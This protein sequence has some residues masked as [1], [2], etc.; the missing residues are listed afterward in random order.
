MVAAF[1]DG[2]GGYQGQLGLPLQVGDGG[3]AHV[4]HG[5]LDL[6]EAGLHVVMEGAGGFPP[7]FA[8]GQL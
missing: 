2:D 5:G 1:H 6:V 4:A 3:D 7:S 8:Y